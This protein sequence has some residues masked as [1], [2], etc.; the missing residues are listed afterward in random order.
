MEDVRLLTEIFL[1]KDL[2]VDF[3]NDYLYN[4]LIRES[5]L[6]HGN[7]NKIIEKSEK[8]LIS[9]EKILEDTQYEKYILAEKFYAY[10][11]CKAN[12]I[13]SGSNESL[14]NIKIW[15]KHKNYK[16]H[17]KLC[18]GLSSKLKAF[19]IHYH[20]SFILKIAYKIKK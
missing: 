4:Y 12:K 5:S 1:N 13:K 16:V 6:S 18:N 17:K 11:M 14:K 8:F 3:I 10:Y 20:L 19:M 9:I 15:N 2:K 7:L